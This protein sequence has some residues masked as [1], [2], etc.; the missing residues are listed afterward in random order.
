MSRAE[1]RRLRVARPDGTLLVG[2]AIGSPE[3]PVVL[4]VAGGDCPM[5]WWR[6]E[7][8]EAI[9]EQ[10][11]RV[12]RYDQRGT[13]ETTLGPTERR[14][15]GV[16]AAIGDA[17]A[18]LDTVGADDAHWVGCSAG[19]WI[20]QLAALD[21]P[22]RVRALTLV[23]TTPAWFG[24]GDDDLPEPSARLQTAWANPL[25]DPD[26]SNPDSIVEYHVAIDRDYAGDE[27]DE[28]HDRAIWTD[29]VRRSPAPRPDDEPAAFAEPPRWRERLG[30]I[31]VPTTV[32]HGTSDPMFPV[33][34]GEALAR[35]IP[36][37]RFVPL[38]GIGH[39]LPPPAW[40]AVIDAVIGARP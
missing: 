11:Y 25:P 39:E 17:L 26:R 32:L 20:A 27:F 10:G 40:D 3:H 9:A 23:S 5:D 34:N 7:F 19:G 37:A 38:A 24:S 6:P 29:A 15:P 21:H 28:A 30:E 33:A 16:T 4:L 18:L 31:R 8:C 36:G 2:E 35:D 12:I 1:V 13:G 14:Q 22:E